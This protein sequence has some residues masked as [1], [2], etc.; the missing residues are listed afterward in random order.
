MKERASA[1]EVRRGGVR[2]MGGREG[3]ADGMWNALRLT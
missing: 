1:S 3:G 2:A